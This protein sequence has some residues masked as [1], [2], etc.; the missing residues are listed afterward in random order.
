MAKVDAKLALPASD[1]VQERLPHFGVGNAQIGQCLP[2]RAVAENTHQQGH[3]RPMLDA[4]DIAK[5]LAQR[6]TGVIAGQPRLPAP[7]FGHF[8]QGRHRQ[9]PAGPQVREQRGL[10]V[11]APRMDRQPGGERRHHFG[12][13][14]D[15]ADFPGFLLADEQ[16]V[17]WRQPTHLTNREPHEFTGAQGRVRAGVEDRQVPRPSTQVKLDPF[18]IGVASDRLDARDGTLSRMIGVPG[19]GLAASFQLARAVR[20]PARDLALK[21]IMTKERDLST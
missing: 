9:R 18:P 8:A 5:R 3:A 7:A 16:V 14:G 10:V 13:Q 19:H 6:M 17:P 12:A 1:L 21:Q 20:D 2:F 4:L 15:P 11:G